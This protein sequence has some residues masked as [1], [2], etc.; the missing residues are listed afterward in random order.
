MDSDNPYVEVNLAKI[1]AY[2]KKTDKA[3][4]LFKKGIP[5]F[6]DDDPSAFYMYATALKNAGKPAEA[7][8]NIRKSLEL[9]P[10]NIDAHR[11]LAEILT[12]EG[13]KDDAAEAIKR[14]NQLVKEAPPDQSSN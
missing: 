12:L 8:S 11:L 3:L 10:K 2:Q 1:Y 14:L 6:Q 13:K 7:E 4:V 9:E 5:Q